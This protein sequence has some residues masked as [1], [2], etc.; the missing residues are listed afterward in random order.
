MIDIKAPVKQPTPVQLFSKLFQLRDESNLRHLQPTNP[1]KPGSGWEHKT[2][3]DFYEELLDLIDG[4]LESYQGKYGVQTLQIDTTKVG[5][6][7]MC[8]KE[9]ATMLEKYE[10]QES[11]LNNQVDEITTLIYST[12]YKLNNLT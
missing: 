10:F 1:G 3:N 12:L 4:L 7:R 6:I 9:T 11:W 5:D 8:L 2:L